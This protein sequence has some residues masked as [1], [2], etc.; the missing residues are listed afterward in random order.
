MNRK[1]LIFG[2]LFILV[3]ILSGCSS[4]TSPESMS[5]SDVAEY[6]FEGLMYSGS[7]HQKMY[8]LLSPDVKPSDYDQWSDGIA[9]KLNAYYQGGVSFQFMSVEN[10]Q[11][12]DNK[13]TVLVK[14]KLIARGHP[15]TKKVDVTL[16][17]TDEGWKL[18][19]KYSLG[20]DSN[21]I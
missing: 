8:D 21:G 2:I 11:I 6:Y 17:K 16:I 7:N 3:L 10:E 1:Q 20:R 12:N 13:A 5:P 4:L 15:I 9:G 19:E 14:Y 18:T